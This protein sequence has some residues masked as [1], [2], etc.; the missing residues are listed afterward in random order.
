MVQSASFQLMVTVMA[1]W[2]TLTSVIPYA[3]LRIF[4]LL[5]GFATPCLH[6]KMLS[7]E[8]WV[9]STWNLVWIQTQLV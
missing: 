2:L 1:S 3:V 4:N 8:I 9:L 6:H 7:G 5:C